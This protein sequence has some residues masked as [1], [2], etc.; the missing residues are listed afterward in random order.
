ML[1][2]RAAEG[3]FF[4]PFAPLPIHGTEGEKESARGL[5]VLRRKAGHA[6]RNCPFNFSRNCHTCTACAAGPTCC[7]RRPGR[8]ACRPGK[9]KAWSARCTQAYLRGTGWWVLKLVC[10]SPTHLGRVGQVGSRY[11]FYIV[12]R[13]A[14]KLLT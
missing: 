2:H 3:P 7:Q 5:T 11:R 6:M 10:Q 14:C 4:T 13:N 12:T 1:Y 9:M 8:S